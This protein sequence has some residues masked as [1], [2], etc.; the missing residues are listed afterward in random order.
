MLC[1]YSWIFC[2][3][4]DICNAVCVGNSFEVKIETDSDKVVDIKTEADR[5]DITYVDHPSIGMLAVF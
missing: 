2:C 5:N 4:Y 3:D 1:I